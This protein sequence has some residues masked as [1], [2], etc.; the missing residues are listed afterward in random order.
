MM[1]VTYIPESPKRQFVG[2]YLFVISLKLFKGYLRY[3]TLVGPK[4]ALDVQLMIFFI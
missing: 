2:F 3:N 1:T 4:V